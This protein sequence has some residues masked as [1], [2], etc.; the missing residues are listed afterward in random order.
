[1]NSLNGQKQNVMQGVRDIEIL[2]RDGF[3]WYNHVSYFNAFH[4]GGTILGRVI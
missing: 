4:A 2:S 1:M 3:L